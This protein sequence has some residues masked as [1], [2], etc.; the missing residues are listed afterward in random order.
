MPYI[1][2]KETINEIPVHDSTVRHIKYYKNSAGDPE[3]EIKLLLD[4][5]E[6]IE[7]SDEIKS[8]I[9]NNGGCR[10]II[11]NCKSITT[12]INCMYSG[13]E[14]ID[15]IEINRQGSDW[16]E[17]VITMISGSIWKCTAKDS[18]LIR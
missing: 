14:E 4:P 6:I 11:S 5:K 13:R 3:L 9:C 1:I 15:Y 12:N 18:L 16:K 8:N 2:D 7:L 10:L 17:I